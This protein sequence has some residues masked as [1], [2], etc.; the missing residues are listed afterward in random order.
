MDKNCTIDLI[1]ATKTLNALGQ[2][3]YTISKRTV[4]AKATSVTQSEWFEGGRIGLNPQYRFTIFAG[5]Y[6]G[7]TEL[8]YNSKRYTIYRTYYAAGDTVELYTEEKK[9]VQATTP[10]NQNGRQTPLNEA[11]S[12][13]DH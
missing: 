7:E 6:G 13:A 3:G 8:E 11:V 12:D 4:Y 2:Y 1:V 5:D 10:A 9:G